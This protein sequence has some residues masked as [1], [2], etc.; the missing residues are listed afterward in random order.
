MQ[1]LIEFLEDHRI[2]SYKEHV[3]LSM[4]STFKA[5]GTCPLVVYPESIEKLTVLLQY[6]K[7]QSIA[8]KII[9]NGSNLIFNDGILPFVLIKL[10]HI[11]HLEI[12]DTK[13]VVGAGYSLMKLALDLSKR[14]LSGLEFATGIPGTVGGSV[15]MNA[16][17]YKNDM[18]EIIT[19]IKVLDKELN[20]TILK[21]EDLDFRYRHSKLQENKDLICLEATLQ[22]KEGDKESILA[23]IEDRKERRLSSQPWDYPSAGSVFRNPEG[24][25]A[26][27]LIEECGLKGYRIG[28]AVV[29]E[30]HA[31]FIINVG[32]AK[33][34][35][36]RNLI[37]YISREV[38]KKFHV[39]FQIEQEFVGWD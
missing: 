12:N 34:N 7:E 31:N 38:E 5:G 30:K 2:D 29:S 9:G 17:A 8:F 20:V 11:N 27:R 14:G 22:L 15:Y 3:N 18:S 16:G 23:L 37:L 13:V 21:N 25:F 39:K 26:G 36:I 28:D 10:D 4:L 24:D 32:K 35:D 19:E 33:G 6:L 1:N